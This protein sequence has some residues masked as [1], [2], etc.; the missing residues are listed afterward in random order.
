[1]HTATRDLISAW[2]LADSDWVYTGVPHCFAP[3]RPSEHGH[4]IGLVSVTLPLRCDS[5]AELVGFMRGAAPLQVLVVYGS[6]RLSFTSKSPRSRHSLPAHGEAWFQPSVT[7]R[8]CRL[9]EA[10]SS[11]AS[12]TSSGCFTRL[13][14]EVVGVATRGPYT[15]APLPSDLRQAWESGLRA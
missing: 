8:T 3:Q 11:R 12:R 13:T 9:P 6:E 7:T 2:L 14:R 4:A 1:M 5:A 15:K 10:S